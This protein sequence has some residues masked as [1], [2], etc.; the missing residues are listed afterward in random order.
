MATPI[1]PGAM[2][3]LYDDWRMSPALEAG[4]FLFLTG[5]SG[6]PPTGEPSDDAEAQIREAFSQIGMVLD[7]AGLGFG[8]LIEMTSYH[9]GLQ[10]HLDL[11]KAIRSEHVVEPYPAWTAVEVVG[12]ATPGVIVEI[13]AIARRP[14]R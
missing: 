5:F 12:F 14:K 4:G 8:D 10:D 6:A 7:E 3:T 13:R 11:F 9:V 2:R 1:V